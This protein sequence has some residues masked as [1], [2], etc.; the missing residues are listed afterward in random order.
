MSTEGDDPP[1]QTVA[2]GLF[3]QG[4]FFLPPP[5]QLQGSRP[6]PIL[7]KSLSQL[8]TLPAKLLHSRSEYS[9]SPQAYS[10]YSLRQ[11]PRQSPSSFSQPSTDFFHRVRLSSL[12]SHSQEFL[13]FLRQTVIVHPQHSSLLPGH[14]SI[15]LQLGKV[16]DLSGQVYELPINHHRLTSFPIL[17]LYHTPTQKE[18][19][20]TLE[21]LRKFLLPYQ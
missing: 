9:S 6:E 11:T 2:S 1:I 13:T 17:P 18:I 20:R 15:D 14:R 12:L 19:P 16:L 7:T 4:S 3:H 8:S 10:F 5:Q 21:A